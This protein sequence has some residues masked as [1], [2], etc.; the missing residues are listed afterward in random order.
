MLYSQHLVGNRVVVAEAIERVVLLLESTQLVQAPW[1]IAI[2]LLHGLEAHGI[3]DVG[4]RLARRLARI[5]QI[6][7]L[8]NPVQGNGIETAV[9]DVVDVNGSVVI[10]IG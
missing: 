6:D 2:P 10:K 5:P 7:R 8:L 4:A 9:G 3:V 1:L